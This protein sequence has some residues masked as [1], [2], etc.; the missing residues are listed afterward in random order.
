MHCAAHRQTVPGV[1]I[2]VEL[3]QEVSF[4]FSACAEASDALD[5]A[6]AVLRHISVVKGGNLL[7]D[8]RRELGTNAECEGIISQFLA[9]NRANTTE[10]GSSGAKNVCSIPGQYSGD[11]TDGS[12]EDDT[13]DGAGGRSLR[14]ER[15]EVEDGS[16]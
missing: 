15:D 11:G 13:R 10:A 8:V 4:D 16:L 3:S 9:D 14:G 6:A 5:D 1:A 12:G 7:D 2:S